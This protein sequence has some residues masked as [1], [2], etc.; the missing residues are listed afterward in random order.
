MTPL[1]HHAQKALDHL[2]AEGRLIRITFHGITIYRIAEQLRDKSWLPSR[3]TT[4]TFMPAAID[5]LI[6][7]NLVA[8]DGPGLVKR[9]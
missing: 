1:S 6:S 7:R 3:S 2:T 4:L 5:E 9:L 8:W